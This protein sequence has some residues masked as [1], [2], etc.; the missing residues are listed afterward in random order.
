M[1]NGAGNAY[2]C[3]CDG[4]WFEAN[5]LAAKGSTKIGCSFMLFGL[6]MS[7]GVFGLIR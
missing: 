2:I 1:W 4:V 5:G 6:V 7:L 3:F